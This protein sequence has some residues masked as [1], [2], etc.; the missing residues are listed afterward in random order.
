MQQQQ[1]ELPLLDDF[2]VHLRQGDLMR[3]V[4]PTVRQGGVGL[5]MVMVRTSRVHLSY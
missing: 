4:V 2:H 5:C 3:H 1:L